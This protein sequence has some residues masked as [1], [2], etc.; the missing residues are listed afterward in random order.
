[1]NIEHL[2]EYKLINYAYIQYKT[3]K[4]KYY[5][6]IQKKQAD[7]SRLQKFYNTK[8]GK[9]C[10]I[11]GNGP[12]LR[13]EDLERIK[14]DTFAVN[15][16]YK[17]FDKTF[18]RPAYYFSQDINVLDEIK[19]DIPIITDNCTGVFLNSYV[20]RKISPKF[21]A[22]KNLFLFF[23]DPTEKFPALPDFAYDISQGFYEGYTVTYTCI[24][25]AVYMG[26]SEIYIMGVDHNYDIDRL[27]D[28]SIVQDASVQN[29]MQG[30]GGNL[31]FPP[32]LLK[33]TLAYRKARQVCD[34]KGIK[35]CN[36][37]RGGKLE[38]F[39]RVNFDEIV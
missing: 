20:A 32:Q 38:E 35:I 31:G 39:I 23:L 5:A 19:D 33:S 1:M 7:R 15:R 37:T 26:Y 10:F 4:K 9:R 17:I 21:K 25:M 12:S 2:K 11:I 8:V 14:D 24:Q 16:I 3:C 28:G 13:I 27:L 29:Y 36:A 30:L 22:K 34:E 18:W 6:S